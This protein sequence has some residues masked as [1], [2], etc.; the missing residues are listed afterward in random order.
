M[1]EIESTKW[2]KIPGEMK[3]ID[4]ISDCTQCHMAYIATAKLGN[5]SSAAHA[6]LGS[7]FSRVYLALYE[8]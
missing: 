6:I 1:G 3:V 8:S 7:S 5:I 4:R 2:L